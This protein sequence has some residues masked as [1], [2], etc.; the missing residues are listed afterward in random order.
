MSKTFAPT[1]LRTLFL[2]DLH[3]GA[4]AARPGAVL[5]FL[6][7]HEAD[8]IYLVGDVLDLWHG[9]RVHWSDEAQAVVDEL[10]ARAASGVRIVYLAGNHDAVLRTARATLPVGWELREA[11]THRASDGQKYLVLHGDQADNRLLRWHVMTRIGSRADAV[12]RLLDDWIARLAGH[13][14]PVRPSRVQRIIARVNGF[15]A[16]GGRFE[17]RLIALAKAAGTDGVICGHSHKPALRNVDG[18][19]YANCGD[20]VDSLT[21]LTETLDGTLQLVEWSPGEARAGVTQGAG[22]PQEA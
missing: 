11:L 7:A 3:L 16:M 20:W 13:A 17:S 19:L 8:M 15:L 10:E 5:D 14:D 22:H 4:R 12:L 21:A 1:R 18:A 6:A 2:S 9:G